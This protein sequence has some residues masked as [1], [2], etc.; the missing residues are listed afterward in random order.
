[1]RIDFLFSQAEFVP[2]SADS[3]DVVDCGFAFQPLRF[4]S[5]SA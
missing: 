1:V 4:I 2:F 3:F 5:S